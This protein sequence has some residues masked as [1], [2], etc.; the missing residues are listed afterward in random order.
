M[1]GW[2]Q[3]KKLFGFTETKN[4]KEESNKEYEAVKKD[5][6]SELKRQ[7]RPEF[8]NRIDEIIVFHKLV[9]E[10]IKQIIEIMLKQVK[11]RLEEQNMI[12]EIDDSVKE[13]I[14]KKGIDT[15]F[16]ARPLRRAI[17]SNLEDRI[18][19][20]ILDGIIKPGEPVKVIAINDEI[21]VNKM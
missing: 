7:F 14:A 5:V 12:V 13:L 3:I 21:Q 19:E 8:I 20:S 10:E 17:Q 15:N 2:L 4:S 9:E 1:Q 11:T 16:G 6:L 18:A